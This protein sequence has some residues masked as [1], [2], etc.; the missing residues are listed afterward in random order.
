MMSFESYSD[1][2]SA[3][4]DYLLGLRQERKMLAVFYNDFSKDWSD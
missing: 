1:T 3:E 4:V 2:F